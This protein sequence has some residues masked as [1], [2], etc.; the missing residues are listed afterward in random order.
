MNKSDTAHAPRAPQE[1]SWSSVPDTM[2][3]DA[4]FPVRVMAGPDRAVPDDHGYALFSAMSRV[5]G[6]WIHGDRDIAIHPLRGQHTRPGWL[7]PMA[8]VCRLPRARVEVLRPL[9]GK[10]LEIVPRT[11]RTTRVLRVESGPHLHEL[12]PA[13]A[14]RAEINFSHATENDTLARVR[15]GERLR[16]MGIEAPFELGASRRIRIGHGGARIIEVTV[17]DLAPEDALVLQAL[18]MGGRRR[19]GCGVFVPVDAGRRMTPATPSPADAARALR[20]ALRGEVRDG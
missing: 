12:A 16:E 14:L 9:V 8:L 18:G 19:F 10:E 3:V 5:L 20:L 7:Q 17:Y 2:P 11:E 4:I 6:D 15:V 1:T 13:R